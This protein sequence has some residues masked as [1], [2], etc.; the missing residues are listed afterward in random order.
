MLLPIKTFIYIYYLIIS[1]VQDPLNSKIKLN[2]EPSV[3]LIANKSIDSDI[4]PGLKII[5]GSKGKTTEGWFYWE[6]VFYAANFPF[7]VEIIVSLANLEQANYIVWVSWSLDDKF[8]PKIDNG[9]ISKVISFKSPFLA[10]I[11]MMLPQKY[12]ISISHI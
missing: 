11:I 4:F 5:I 6:A 12:L 10:I 9:E 2:D 8:V 1:F 3:I 7:F